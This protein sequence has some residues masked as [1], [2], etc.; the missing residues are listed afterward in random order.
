MGECQCE[1]EE[2]HS[3]SIQ[4]WNFSCTGTINTVFARN[5]EAAKSTYLNKNYVVLY[6]WEKWSRTVN[7]Y[8]NIIPALSPIGHACLRQF[9]VICFHFLYMDPVFFISMGLFISTV[10]FLLHS[11]VLGSCPCFLHIT[12]I[13]WMISQFPDS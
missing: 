6:T 10:V 9:S 2:P 12:R 1:A 8:E 11:S 5:K 4:E 7:P 13:L 3:G